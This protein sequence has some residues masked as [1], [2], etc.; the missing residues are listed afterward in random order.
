MVMI[1]SAI[2]FFTEPDVAKYVDPGMSV[3]SA[4]LL[5]YLKYPN[6]KW[7]WKILTQN[8]IDTRIHKEAGHRC[9]FTTVYFII[10]TYETYVLI[11]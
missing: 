11:F 5:L 10:Y 8:R 3:I 1:C 4:A 9:R 2:V 6:S 7:F